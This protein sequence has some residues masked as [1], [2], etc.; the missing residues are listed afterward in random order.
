MSQAIVCRKARIEDLERVLAIESQVFHADS[1]SRRQLRYLMQHAKGAFFVAVA[2]GIVVGYISVLTRSNRIGRIYSLAVDQEYRGKG[3]AELLIDTAVDFMHAQYIERIFLEVAVDNVAAI[4]L[5]EKK[6][7]IKRSIKPG[8]YDSG[9]DAYS[10]I[11]VI[12]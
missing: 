6:H 10:M 8:Y 2:R 7:F 5:Y 3:I 11:C 12:P 4:S 1:F 9:A